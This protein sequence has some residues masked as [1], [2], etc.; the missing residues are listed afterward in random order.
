MTP[1]IAELLAT[2]EGRARLSAALALLTVDWLT[3]NRVRPVAVRRVLSRAW[4]P[5]RLARLRTASPDALRRAGP[6]AVVG[7]RLGTTTF[8]APSDGNHRTELA[9]ERGKRSIRA[10]VGG[11]WTCDPARF[12]FDH[13][14]R[15]WR[16]EDPLLR[17]RSELGMCD[18]ALHELLAHL[19]VRSPHAL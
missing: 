7:Y 1:E 15:L 4:A 11:E 8:Y 5:S 9:R 13:A 19:G 14:M 6:I 18:P 10:E 16:I 12:V 2:G 3:V 17:L